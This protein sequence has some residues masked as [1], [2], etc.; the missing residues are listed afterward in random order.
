MSLI[1]IPWNQFKI[2]FSFLITMGTYHINLAT[3]TTLSAINWE[4]FEAW[5][6][7]REKR[8]DKSYN[9]KSRG[10]IIEE[11]ELTLE[12]LICL[13]SKNYILLIIIFLYIRLRW[14]VRVS[15]T[16]VRLRSNEY[17]GSLRV[18]GP[19]LRL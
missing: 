7:K 6:D 5:R 10:G 18:V 8:Q 12:H 14:L 19:A 15:T 1:S 3:S 17:V 9:C 11:F 4:V 13:L 16:Q 2:I